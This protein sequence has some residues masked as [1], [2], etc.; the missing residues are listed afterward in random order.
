MSHRRM[1]LMAWFFIV[2]SMQY[3]VARIFQM[4]KEGL[5]RIQKPNA[6]DLVLRKR[7]FG[8]LCNFIAVSC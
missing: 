1:L 8:Y 2:S 3:Y 4:E 5:R 7:L 6:V